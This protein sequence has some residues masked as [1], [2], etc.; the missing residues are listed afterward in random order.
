MPSLARTRIRKRNHC[1]R[2]DKSLW[3]T[4]RFAFRT[5]M[6]TR[7]ISYATER[8]VYHAAARKVVRKTSWVVAIIFVFLESII[9]RKLNADVAFCLHIDSGMTTKIPARIG[10][11][12]SSHNLLRYL[13]LWAEALSVKSV[14]DSARIACKNLLVMSVFSVYAIRVV[15]FLYHQAQ[16]RSTKTSHC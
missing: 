14:F 4:P 3:V 15:I 7:V 5:S 13:P 10:R 2:C 9:N 12:L 11:E 16:L 6:K 8:A 1:S